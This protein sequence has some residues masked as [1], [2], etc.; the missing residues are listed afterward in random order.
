[1]SQS[2]SD[3]LLTLNNLFQQ[4]SC[5][6]DTKLSLEWYAKWKI[7][8][9]ISKILCQFY[10]ICVKKS[11]FLINSVPHLNRQ[12]T[13]FFRRGGATDGVGKISNGRHYVDHYLFIYLFIHLF[14]YCSQRG[15]GANME[16]EISWWHSPLTLALATH[17]ATLRNQNLCQT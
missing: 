13:F 8:N 1:M 6:T 14:F 17:L 4:N 12:F 2:L 9:H 15:K 3:I 5:C 10:W 16:Q 11:S 7:I